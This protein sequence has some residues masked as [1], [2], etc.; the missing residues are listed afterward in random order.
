MSIDLTDA[1]MDTALEN[2]VLAV[3]DLAKPVHLP[4]FFG[5]ERYAKMVVLASRANV[6][7]R[8]YLSRL[9]DDALDRP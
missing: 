3:A 8:D 2:A 4:T 1:E 6:S 5:V 9:V 7:V